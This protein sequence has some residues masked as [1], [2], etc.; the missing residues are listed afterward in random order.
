M[1]EAS[2]LELTLHNA[3]SWELR[4]FA[5]R[6]RDFKAYDLQ[7]HPEMQ[8]VADSLTSTGRLLDSQGFEAIVWEDIHNSAFIRHCVNVAEAMGY[9]LY[10]DKRAQKQCNR[11]TVKR[12][13]GVSNKVIIAGTL[14]ADQTPEVILEAALRLTGVYAYEAPA[15]APSAVKTEVKA[16]EVTHPAKTAA[17]KV[18]QPAATKPAH[19]AKGKKTKSMKES[20]G[21]IK[22]ADSFRLTPAQYFPES[23]KAEIAEHEAGAVVVILPD[24]HVQTRGKRVPKQ[25]KPAVTSVPVK[26]TRPLLSE[27]QEVLTKVVRF[28]K[29]GVI[30]QD[31]LGNE[32]FLSFREKGAANKGGVEHDRLVVKIDDKV[33]V[34]VVTVADHG[35]AKVTLLNVVDSINHYLSCL[36]IGDVQNG[37]VSRRSEHC[38][39]VRLGGGIV[40]IL[41]VRDIPNLA[42]VKDKLRTD[43]RLNVRITSVNAEKRNFHVVIESF[44]GST[45]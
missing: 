37:L 28:A 16:V 18:D 4:A 8:F 12:A 19:P 45:N 32:G 24:L 39:Y 31:A 14:I 35:F 36:R 10:F 5:K 30:V 3:N 9:N 38:F 20:L 25:P 15:A 44:P 27:G 41:A 26:P 33:K 22:R 6:L 11:L 43:T 17:V 1:G 2:C 13:P 42:E 40:G 34:K 23:G 7:A 21:E 29:F